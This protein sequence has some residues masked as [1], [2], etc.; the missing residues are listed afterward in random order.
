MH[1]SFVRTGAWLCAALTLVSC[2]STSEPTELDRDP[3]DLIV[4]ISGLPDSTFA[5][6]FTISDSLVTSQ[7]YAGP[8]TLQLPS[9]RVTVTPIRVTDRGIGYLASPVSVQIEPLGT[10]TVELQYRVG[11]LP[12]S[13]TNRADETS[14]NKVKLVYAV[15]SDGSD[16]GLDTNG[17][18]HRTISSGQRW[19]A[20]QTAG[21]YIRYDAAD[22]ALDVAFV[23][24]PRTD[25]AYFSYGIFLRDTIEKDLRAAG[26]TQAN[27]LFLTYYDGRQADRCG[28][29]A[30]PPALVGNVA[31]M[32]LQG[33]P[34]GPVPCAS[35]TFAS[36]A[37]A[38]PGYWEFAAVHEL[39]HLM[40]IVSTSAP[41]HVLA[42]HV[43]NDPTDLMY[44]GALPWRPAVVDVT[45]SNYYNATGLP[46]GVTN[47]ISSP[48]VVA[49]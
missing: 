30:W 2:N 36:T 17:T 7:V 27:T 1:R 10:A 9:V 38:A 40:G 6:G 43:G 47:F 4:R 33:I 39:F 45:K 19:L 16:R 20:S 32:Y 18:L 37:I 3:G 28:G 12:R 21:R 14:L 8:R 31:A 49:P 46:A 15:P 44:A 26:W 25:A 34:T 35:N 23:R 42:G 5:G 48:Y 22:G 11:V 29:A 24:L 13:T 41:N